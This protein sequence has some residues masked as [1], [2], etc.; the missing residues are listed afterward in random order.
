MKSIERPKS[1]TEL[2]AEKLREFI[3]SGELGLGEQLSEA[4][5]SKELEVSR[6]PVREA[7][8]RLEIE[9]LLRVVPQSGT[10]VFSLSSEELAE[11]CD[12]RVYLETAALELCMQSNSEQLHKRLVTCVANMELALSK[13]DISGYLML[14]AAFHQCL[15]DCCQNR[16]LNEAYQSFAQK[17]SAIRSRIGGL[18]DHLS[19]SFREHTE[20]A[21]IVKT[22]NLEKANELLLFHIDRR[23]GSYWNTATLGA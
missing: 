13:N 14:D 18:P 6:T 2:V 1:L 8:N 9:G 3:V 20:F 12:A 21:E 10:F 16:F 23:E 22:G 17:M 4:R 15:F 7:F 19:K 5:I 11:L